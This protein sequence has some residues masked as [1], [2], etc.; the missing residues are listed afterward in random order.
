[1]KTKHI[2]LAIIASLAGF[3]AM[4]PPGPSGSVLLTWTKHPED[5]TNIVFRVYGSSS[6]TTPLSNW[7]VMVAVPATNTTATNYSATV[8]VQPGAFYFTVTAS[9]FWG[10]SDFSAVAVAPSLPRSD[11]QLKL[12]AQ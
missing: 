10:E 5:D 8:S 1:M 4:K 2:L 3:A 11:R 9:N 12:Q 6:I 7:A